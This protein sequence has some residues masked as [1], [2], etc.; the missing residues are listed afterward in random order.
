MTDQLSEENVG[1]TVIICNPQGE[2][3]LGKRK[4]AYKSGYFGTPGGH[5]E[6][7]ESVTD[8]CKREVMEETGIAI[9]TNHLEYV[10][11]VRELQDEGPN[12][13][14]HFGFVIRNFTGEVINKEPHKCEGW[15]YFAPEALPENILPGHKAVIAMYFHPDG[16]NMRD[17]I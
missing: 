8:A 16:V 1:V 7:T 6:L 9:T 13:F 11:V 12:T 4:N 10:G 15:K 5:V 3:L 2:I 17:I 14:I